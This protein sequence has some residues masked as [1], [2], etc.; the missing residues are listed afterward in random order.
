MKITVERPFHNGI[1]DV[2]GHTVTG[3]IT[4]RQYKRLTQSCGPDCKCKMI[5]KLDGDHAAFFPLDNDKY[6]VNII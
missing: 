4:R 5:V 1:C 2:A 6:T 3:T